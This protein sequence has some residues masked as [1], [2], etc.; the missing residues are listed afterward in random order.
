MLHSDDLLV[1]LVDIKESSFDANSS[2]FGSDRN[3]GDY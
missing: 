1:L 2:F 3:S